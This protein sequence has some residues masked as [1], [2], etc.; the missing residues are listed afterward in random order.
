M[1]VVTTTNL[2]GLLNEAHAAGLVTTSDSVEKRAAAVG[3]FTPLLSERDGAGDATRWAV[4]DSAGAGAVT[5]DPETGNYPAAQ[6]MTFA[7][8]ELP[9]SKVVTSFSVSDHVQDVLRNPSG[10]NLANGTNIVSMMLADAE[11]KVRLKIETM[12]IAA[13][14]SATTDIDCLGNIIVATG[15]YA[16]LNHTSSYWLPHVAAI[17]GAWTTAAMDTF[18]ETYRGSTYNGTGSVALV[19]Y[20]QFHKIANVLK[21]N[22]PIQ[23]VGTTELQAGVT[24]IRYEDVT[25]VP[26]SGLASTVLYLVDPNDFELVMLPTAEPFKQ[27]GRT[28][29]A[30]QIVYE[31]TLALKCNSPRNQA[32]MTGLS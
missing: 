1:A 22:N 17:G 6:N 10:A 14:K 2:A 12:A 3:A 5:I 28:G 13:S 19:S 31:K 16:G 18:L 24:G 20:A 23:Y 15:T 27:L 7:Q 26:I 4:E 9:W 32:A 8:A 21:T 25:I 29:P 30:V 11:R